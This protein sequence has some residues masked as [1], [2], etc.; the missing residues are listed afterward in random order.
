MKTDA[1]VKK[2]IEDLRVAD[3]KT[4]G[5][6]VSARKNS[7]NPHSDR[8]QV[9]KQLNVLA[10]TGGLIRG[11]GWYATPA[12]RGVF[13][14]HDRLLTRALAEILKLNY[15][16]VIFREVA[17]EP[18]LRSDAAVLLR[19]DGVG[20]CF[21]LECIHTE[22]PTYTT[23]KMKTWEHWQGATEALSQLFGYRIPH[24]TVLTHDGTPDS[25]FSQLL[26]KIGGSNAQ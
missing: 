8:V 11:D 5:E 22:E 2:I 23:M 6:I 25:P 12:Y 3:A 19:K 14:E 20:L 16:T 13:G 7:T 21:L 26:K 17:F 9:Q 4:V 10:E 1:T 15:E 18:A 24:F